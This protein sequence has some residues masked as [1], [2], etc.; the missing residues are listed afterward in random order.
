MMYNLRNT[1]LGLA[2]SLSF[3]LCVFSQTPHQVIN[4]AG[5]DR[6]AASGSLVLTDNVGE[7]FVSSEPGGNFLITQ[8]FLQVLSAPAMSIYVESSDVSCRG[9][10]D[11]KISTSISNVNPTY[12]LTYIW[13]DSTLCPP[14][15]NCSELDSLGADTLVLTVIVLRPSFAGS[16]VTVTDTLR[17]NPIRILDVNPQCQVTVFTGITANEDNINDFF[18]IKNIEQFPNNRVSIYNRW[19]N[20]L[21]EQSGYSNDLTDKRW[22]TKEHLETLV[23]GTYFYILDLGEGGGLIKGWVELLKNN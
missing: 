14:Q 20:L 17:T 5:G 16:S 1:K 10:K 12:T 4:S 6:P 21:Y 23:S 22:P 18:H 8:G 15:N 7:T 11:G 9:K 2:L 3:S 19:G 13:S